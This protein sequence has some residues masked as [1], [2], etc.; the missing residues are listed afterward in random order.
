MTV[1][2]RKIFYKS[3]LHAQDGSSALETLLAISIVL[4]ITPLLYNQISDMTHEVQDMAMANKIVKL[5]DGVINFVRVNQ[6]QWPEVAEVKLEE[7]DISEIAPDAHSVFI[8]KYKVNGATITDVYVAFDID[9][10]SYRAANIAK[11]I[12]QNAA[13]V[14]EDNVAYAQS[15]AVSAPSEFHVGDLI[16]KISRDFDGEDR[17]RFLH[18]ATMGEDGLNQ[19]NRDLYM[20]NFNIFNVG[21]ID[22]VSAKI[23]DVDATFVNADVVDTDNAYFTSGA[24]LKSKDAQFGSMRVTGD[25]SGFRK[26]IADKLNND[27]Y[28][29][30]GR[31]VVDSATIEDSVNVSGNLILKSTS[32]K[33]VTG[34][35]G[36]SASKLLTPYV[37]ATNMIFYE[38]FGITVSGELLMTSVAPLQI[39]SWS[40]PTNVPPSFS[41][42]EITRTKFP[43]VPDKKKFEKL[44]SKDWQTQ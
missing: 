38:N 7:K 32:A 35:A 42:F 15:W 4:V 1:C 34:F 9:D 44:I 33:T 43:S 26:I 16:Y 2:K 23:I 20:N 13:I 28:T 3:N 21:S 36:I 11:Y 27:K 8:D 24:I 29:T 17:T 6:N 19:M 5:R 12:G 31:L 18:R 37:S 40:F 25:V 22:A 10:S 30:N 41:K 39:G 14:R